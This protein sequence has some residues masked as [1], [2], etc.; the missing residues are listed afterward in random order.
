VAPPP[1]TPPGARYPAP[2][3][4]WACVGDGEGCGRGLGDPLCPRGV[5]PAGLVGDG[6][7]LGLLADPEADGLGVRDADERAVGEDARLTVDPA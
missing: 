3:D 6:E 4:Q 5:L 2:M 7:V 1:P